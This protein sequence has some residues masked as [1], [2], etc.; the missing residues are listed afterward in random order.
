MAATTNRIWRWTAESRSSVPNSTGDFYDLQSLTVHGGTLSCLNTYGMR[1]GNTYGANNSD[2]TFTFTGVQDGG[3]VN[4]ANN[5]AT[6]AAMVRSWDPVTNG[7]TASYTL[8]RWDLQHVKWHR[9]YLR[10]GY[11]GHRHDHADLGRQRPVECS[12]ISP[13]HRGQLPGRCSISRAARSW[14]PGSTPLQLSG[15]AAPSRAGH[16]LQ[17]GRHPGPRRH[18]HTGQDHDYRQLQR[19][20]GQRRIGH[21]PGRHDAGH[22]LSELRA[23]TTTRS[24]SP[25]AR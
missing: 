7:I 17:H 16:V 2:R 15:T 14:Q 8:T 10:R 25:T 21:R 9:L 13:A 12:E 11:V 19:H 20:V 24:T 5:N 1:M 23:H 3:L 4:V 6:T 18:R 22:G